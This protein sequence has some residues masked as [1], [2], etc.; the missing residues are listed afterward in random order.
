MNFSR[1]VLCSAILPISIVVIWMW[2]CWSKVYC[3]KGSAWWTPA[4]SWALLMYKAEAGL[5]KWTYTF[6]PKQNIFYWEFGIVETC[7][8]SQLCLCVQQKLISAQTGEYLSVKT[9]TGTRIYLQLGLKHKQTREKGW[10]GAQKNDITWNKLNC[11]TDVAFW[12]HCK[13]Q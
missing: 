1:R 13:R 11:T 5:N 12:K 9:K 6:L 3:N 10:E 7:Q 2:Q 8:N 4:E